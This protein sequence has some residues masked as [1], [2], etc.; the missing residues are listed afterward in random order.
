MFCPMLFLALT[1]I[2]DDPFRKQR[3]EMVQS[4]L[5]ARDIHHKAVLE[6]MGKVPRHEFVPLKARE[7]AYEDQPLP[8]GEGQTI[9][10]PY[11]VALMTQLIRPKEG[12]RVLEIGTGSGYQAAVL[13][14]IVEEV[15]TVEIIEPL[16]LRAKNDLE[17]LGYG[18]VHVKIGDGY[19][20]WAEHAPYDAILVTAAPEE[21]PQ[22]LIDQLKEGGKMVIPVGPENYIQQL[23]LVEKVNGK[24]RK[25]Q[26]TDVRFVPFLRKNEE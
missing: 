25:Q 19:E 22:P 5:A 18:N 10:Q 1:L 4:Q 20:G 12:M 14:E 11:I 16:G 2:Q 3:A 23:L 13:A 7:Y 8:I 17:R 26:V 15:Y 9:S 24:I 6:A 21:I